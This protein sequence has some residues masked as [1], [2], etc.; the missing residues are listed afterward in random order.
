MWLVVASVQ[1]FSVQVG[2]YLR[3]SYLFSD[4]YGLFD[5]LQADK[6]NIVE[7]VMPVIHVLSNNM[8][9]R[10]QDPL[11]KMTGRGVQV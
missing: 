7:Y 1:H 3:Y 10:L 4:P 6:L 2:S 8:L 5:I 9:Q 11:S